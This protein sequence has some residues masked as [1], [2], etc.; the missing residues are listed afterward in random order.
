MA[1]VALWIRSYYATY[2]VAW[3]DSRAT[4]PRSPRFDDRGFSLQVYIGTIAVG[5]FH[6]NSMVQRDTSGLIFRAYEAGDNPTG[7]GNR[8][9]LRKW[10]FRITRD[11]HIDYADSQF[12]TEF[13]FVEVPFWAL[14][15]TLAAV[16]ATWI[17][18]Y[19][20]RRHRRAAGHCPSC[21]YDLR[22]TP[23]RCPECGTEPPKKNS[24]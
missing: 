11:G 22:A 12:V 19:R 21:G 7:P 14:L 24:S 18:T 16:P 17:R 5:H 3:I 6:E 23:E 15:M 9:E 1:T 2:Y 4:S 10:G 20:N 8:L 13:T